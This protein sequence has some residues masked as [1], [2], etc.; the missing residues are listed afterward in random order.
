[1]KLDAETRSLCSRIALERTRP[2]MKQTAE[3]VR[4]DALRVLASG[5]PPDEVQAW[6]RALLGDAMK[7]QATGG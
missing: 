1:M 3:E 4:R 5:R 2:V 7:A 6:L